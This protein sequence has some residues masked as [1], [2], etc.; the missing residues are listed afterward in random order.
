MSV[1][2]RGESVVYWE[3]TLERIPSDFDDAQKHIA[4]ESA[5]EFVQDMLQLESFGDFQVTHLAQTDKVFGVRSDPK[6]K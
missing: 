1:V 6:E 2:V 4:E 3:I 5:L